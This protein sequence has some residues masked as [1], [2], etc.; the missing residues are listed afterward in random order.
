MGS[1]C[2]FFRGAALL[3]AWQDFVDRFCWRLARKNFHSPNRVVAL[4]HNLAGCALVC[5][6]RSHWNTGCIRS[7]PSTFSRA[8][9]HPLAYHRPIHAPNNR[10][11]NR[12]HCLQRLA[13][14]VFALLWELE[15]S[16]NHLCKCIYEL[17][18]CSANRRGRLD[19]VGFRN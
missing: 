10:G 17:L 2:S 4:V 14:S 12:F 8:E 11:G 18:P 3:A 19:D 1:A 15:H 9:I 16:N 7:L 13:R 6:L 5:H